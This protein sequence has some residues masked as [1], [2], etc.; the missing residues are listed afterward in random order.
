MTQDAKDPNVR[1]FVLVSIILATLSVILVYVA[2]GADINTSRVTIPVTPI[3]IGSGQGRAVLD[4]KN[5]DASTS[6][7]CGPASQA[8]TTWWEIS[9][10]EFKSFGIVYRGSYSAQVEFKCY[11][12]AGSAVAHVVEEGGVP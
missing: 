6:I 9:P 5:T 1:D 2:Q 7:F 10:G 4:I 12:T 8:E 3:A 11:V